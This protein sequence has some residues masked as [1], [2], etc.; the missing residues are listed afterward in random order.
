MK[1]GTVYLV[2][3]NVSI[4]EL[5]GVLPLADQAT[6]AKRARGKPTE[7]SFYETDAMATTN[8]YQN[9]FYSEWLV[10]IPFKMSSN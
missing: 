5:F 6:L 3:E 1:T 7:R 9:R 2:E 10:C 4:K 8:F